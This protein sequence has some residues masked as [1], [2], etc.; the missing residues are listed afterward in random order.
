MP[1]MVETM[2]YNI[3]NADGYVDERKVPW[4]GLGTPVYGKIPVNKVLNLAGLD[5][6]VEIGEQIL[7]RKDGTEKVTGKKIT[8]R[9]DTGDDLGTVTDQYTVVQN[10]EALD[11]VNQLID[12]DEITFE[13]AGSLDGGRKIFLLANMPIMDIM[14]DEVIPYVCFSNSHD[15][16]MSVMV[17]MTPVRVVC[18]N[19][20]NEAIQ[21]AKRMWSFVHRGDIN[22]KVHEARE[23]LFNMKNYMEELNKDAER[24]ASI[25]VSGS[26]LQK[27]MNIMFPVDADADYTLRKTK[28][29]MY[30]R[31]MFMGRYNVDD[32]NNFRGTAWGLLNASSDF[33]SHV[34][35][36]RLT[37]NHQEKLFTSFMRGNGFFDKTYD[38]INSIAA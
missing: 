9:T 28:N 13:T 36:L 14:G 12:S 31:E 21:T 16:S 32:L 38:F 37:K 35:P 1:A 11:F 3:L 2:C 15:G 22:S 19:T 34:R 27:F 10:E 25:K 26:D 20:L 5:W 8:Y 23:T 30:L 24:L 17:S 29:I 7:R 18:A 6:T 33:V 4:H